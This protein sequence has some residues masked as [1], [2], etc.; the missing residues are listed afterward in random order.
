MG[1]RSGSI[2][3]VIF[4][5]LKPDIYI[6][7]CLSTECLVISSYAWYPIGASSPMLEKVAG[8]HKVEE[9]GRVGL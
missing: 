2:E 8:N 6:A 1:L 9:E 4:H 3:M 7:A 5:H